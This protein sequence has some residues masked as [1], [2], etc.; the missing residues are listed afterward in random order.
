MGPQKQAWHQKL[1][2]RRGKDHRASTV[3]VGSPDTSTLDDS[4]YGDKY[5][6]FHV[7]DCDPSINNSSYPIDV[8]AVHGVNGDAFHTWTTHGKFWL[9]DFLSKDLPDAR[10]FTFGYASK[11]SFTC[12]RGELRDFARSLLESLRMARP[13]RE[14]CLINAAHR[15]WSS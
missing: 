15:I 6:L 14:V 12:A 2:S 13:T 3:E 4:E 7:C 10:I 1:L 9:R 8:V 5:G 11:I